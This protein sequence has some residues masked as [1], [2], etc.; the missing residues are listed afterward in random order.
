MQIA[1]ITLVVGYAAICFALFTQQ[2]RILFPAPK[3]G[4][5]PAAV[6]PPTG[7][8][9]VYF[10]GNAETASGSRWLSDLWQHASAGFVAVEYPG[11]G[12][13]PG[14]PDEAGIFL[15]AQH[16]LEGL[17]A[18]GVARDRIV[19]VGQSLGTGPAVEMAKRGWGRRV[20]LLTPYTSIS[21]AA[22]LHFPWLP[23][24]WLVRDRF[25]SAASAPKVT[26]PV[27]IVHGTLDEV[28][29][30]VLGQQL[31]AVFPNAEL[32][33]IEGGHHND[34]WDRPDVLEKV[35]RFALSP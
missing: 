28:V 20:V 5:T 34:L 6:I 10:H 30:Y 13:Q 2:R 14:S 4:A 9:I 24:K 25:D 3:G 17:E 29:P 35:T 1:L 23:A 22:Q 19:L 8:V 15:A 11:Y 7:P 16:A 27:L 31:F 18:Q 32:M 21:D 12:D 33:T 26:V